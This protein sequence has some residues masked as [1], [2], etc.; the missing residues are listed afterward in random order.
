MQPDGYKNDVS[1]TLVP[2]SNAIIGFNSTYEIILKNEGNQTI[3]G[4]IKLKFDPLNASYISSL[5]DTIKADSLNYIWKFEN[6]K[7]FEKSQLILF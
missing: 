5:P 7:P 2:T 1:I 6:L 3:S 4:E